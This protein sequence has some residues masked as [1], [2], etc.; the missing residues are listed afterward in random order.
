MGLVRSRS[1]VESSM[2]RIKI[3]I[4]FDARKIQRLNQLNS[5][6]SLIQTSNLPCAELSA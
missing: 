1:N 6:N 2:R 3:I 5:A 4:Q